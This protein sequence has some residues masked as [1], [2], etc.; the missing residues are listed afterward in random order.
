MIRKIILTIVIWGAFSLWS[1]YWIK[2]YISDIYFKKS[3]IYLTA[4]YVDKA[5]E[6]SNKAIKFN[7]FE[8]N[9]Y[10]GRAK[11]L[12]VS[13]VDEK[14]LGA[15]KNRILKDLKK[16]EKLNLN[17]LVT[18]R[19]AVPIYYFLAIGDISLTSGILNLDPVYL[20]VT[21]EFFKTLKETYSHD[22]GVVTLLA[23][24]E[25]KLGLDAEY[26]ESRKIVERLRPE[27]LDWHESFR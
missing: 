1:F 13:L 10:R 3:Q 4:E 19:N 25:K 9:Y 26:L 24:Y 12:T 15:V 11:V 23:K 18:L 20:P 8:P 6:Y 14:D 16:A 17:N 21:K 2:I 7:P 22:V 27:L 5:Q